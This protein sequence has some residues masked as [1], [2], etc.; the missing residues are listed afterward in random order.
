LGERGTLSKRY[1]PNEIIPI[2]V[3]MAVNLLGRLHAN[4]CFFVG[5]NFM[6]K[7]PYNAGF[8][9]GWWTGGKEFS[10]VWEKLCELCAS[11]RDLSSHW[12]KKNPEFPNTGNFGLLTP[13]P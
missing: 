10:N 5:Q 9:A 11:A 7:H 2:A 6:R 4:H 12:K 8:L 1:N 3:P 13:D